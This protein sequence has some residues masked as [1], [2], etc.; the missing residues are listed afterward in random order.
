M[1]HNQLSTN[2]PLANRSSRRSTVGE[3]V[4]QSLCVTRH[5]MV[6]RA[7]NRLRFGWKS[8]CDVEGSFLSGLGGKPP[9]PF[10]GD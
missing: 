2:K 4:L 8:A 9:K 3:R 7:K 10:L 1:L 5:G 6:P